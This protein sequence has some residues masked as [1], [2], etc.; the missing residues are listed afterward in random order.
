MVYVL[1]ALIHE[2]KSTITEIVLYGGGS[3]LLCSA[4]LAVSWWV[5]RLL[6]RIARA[7]NAGTIVDL[8]ERWVEYAGWR[9]AQDATD[10]FSVKYWTQVARR[11][12]F[13]LDDILSITGNDRVTVKNGVRTYS[14]DIT[15]A[16]STGSV[17]IG[18][19]GA[20]QRDQLF[21]VLRAELRMGT[22][23]FEA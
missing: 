8:D 15:L 20:A 9:E 18:F 17:V 21:S 22:P 23:V 16:G 3:G 12:R 14:Y 10:I 2:G 4:L 6:K 5:S 11:Q 7:K 1:G 19:L 13:P